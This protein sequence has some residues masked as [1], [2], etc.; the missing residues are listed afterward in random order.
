MIN[1][2]TVPPIACFSWPKIVKY[3]LSWPDFL[4]L[5]LLNGLRGPCKET[6]NKTSTPATAA[7]TGG[8]VERKIATG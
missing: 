7:A 1:D 5:P 8:E 2:R 6:A 4:T 3:C